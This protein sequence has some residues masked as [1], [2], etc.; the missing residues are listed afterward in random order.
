MNRQI[1]CDV[2]SC[3][4]NKNECCDAAE[5]KV[6]NCQCHGQDARTSEQTECST[7]RQK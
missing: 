7:F 5:I 4:Y 1:K 2:C 3:M 6:S